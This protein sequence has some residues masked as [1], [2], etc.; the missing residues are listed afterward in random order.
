MYRIVQYLLNHRLSSLNQSKGMI[1]LFHFFPSSSL[2]QFFAGLAEN[3][4]SV[5]QS[6]GE[7]PSSIIFF[8]QMFRLISAIL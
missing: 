7:V 4:H 1:L 5:G 2:S 8:W 6:R 3:V